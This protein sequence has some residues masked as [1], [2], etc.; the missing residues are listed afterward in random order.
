[1]YRTIYD[2]QRTQWSGIKRRPLFNPEASLGEVL[3]KAMQ[4]NG[5]KIAQVSFER[6][7]MWNSFQCRFYFDLSIEYAELLVYGKIFIFTSR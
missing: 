4:V 3:L 7:I 6:Q 5:P 2:K 1:M